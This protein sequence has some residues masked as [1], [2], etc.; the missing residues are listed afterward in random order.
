M[1]LKNI[2]FFKQHETNINAKSFHITHGKKVKHF[3]KYLTKF[4]FRQAHMPANCS[5]LCKSILTEFL[6]THPVRLF[7]IKTHPRV[8]GEL[9][10][11]ARNPW[12]AK[13][14]LLS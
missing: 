11:S 7:L 4:T 2:C 1:Y 3:S 6:G 5:Q 9:V 8:S 10:G 13:P 14:K 12:T